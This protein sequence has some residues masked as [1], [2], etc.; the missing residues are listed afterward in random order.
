[1]LA[2]TKRNAPNIFEHFLM[3]YFS[4]IFRLVS[5]ADNYAIMYNIASLV[6]FLPHVEVFSFRDFFG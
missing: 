3:Q 4:K 2:S 6:K 5:K 1:M